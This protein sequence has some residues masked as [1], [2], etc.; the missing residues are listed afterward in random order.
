[1][2]EPL[3][4][5]IVPNYNHA[6]YLRERIDS[7]L[8]QTFQD[9]ELILLDDCSPDNSREIINSYKDNPHVSHIVLNEENTGNTFVQW[10]RGI[11]LARGKYIWIA[12]S[13]DVALPELLGTLV[14][15][16][17]QHPDASVA[18]CHSKLINAEGQVISE[19]N[20]YNPAQSGQVT[21]HDSRQFLRYLL[22]FNYIYN[23]SMAVFC[24]KYY[25][26]ANPDFKGFRFCGDWHFWASIS[27]NGKVIEVHDMLNLFRQHQRKVTEHA[28]TMVA[29]RWKNELQTIEYLCSLCQLSPLERKCLK[30]RLTKRLEKAEMSNAEK[31]QLRSQF[32]ALCDGNIWFILCYEIGKNVFG[33]LKN[34]QKMLFLSR[35]F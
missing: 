2:N 24:R 5:V 22:I 8:N 15:Q 28:K 32:S 3:V 35:F 21:L 10:E 14:E 18:Y 9:F 17:E 1:M 4:S 27:A 25:F 30:G 20:Q 12:E 31:K 7:I 29:L 19:H 16:L 33:F 13:D 23:A 26:T 6:P 34:Y 11:K